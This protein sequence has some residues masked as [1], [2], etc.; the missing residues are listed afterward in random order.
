MNIASFFPSVHLS[1]LLL[2]LFWGFIFF[3][4][5]RELVTWYWKINRIT[6]LLEKI[7][8]HLQSNKPIN[9]S[10]RDTTTPIQSK[11]N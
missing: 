11:T 1:D 5:I 8:K 2:Y 4:V 6:D 10:A 9:E 7:E 3:M